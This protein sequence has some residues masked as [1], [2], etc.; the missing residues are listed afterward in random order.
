MRTI[1]FY[2]IVIG[3][4]SGI[5]TRSF[6]DLGIAE[7]CLLLTVS[8]ACAG[9]WRMGVGNYRSS[10][11]LCSL[12]LF[13]F[14]LGMCR[15]DV[16]ERDV[17]AFAL[18][19]NSK[20]Q[21]MG[22]VAREPDI[23]GR[24]VHLYVLDAR[25]QELL[26]V[27][28]DR[29][30]PFLYGDE[31]RVEGIVKKPEAFETDLGRTFNYEGFLKARGVT[32]MIS[33]GEIE[34]LAHGKGN[35]YLA[36]L[37][38]GKTHF[39]E[40]LEQIIPEPSVGLGE[41]L[42]LG[43]KALGSTLEDTFRQVGIIHIVVLSGY[44]IMI[45]VESIMW[46]LSFW[47]YPRTRM[48]VGIA[49][50]IS[51]ALLVGYSA[52][53]LRASIM[54]GL[55]IIAR[56]TGRTYAI[57]RALMI[58]GMVMLLSNPYLLVFDPGFQL[59]FLATLGLLLLAPR[60]NERLTFVPSFAGAREFLTATLATQIFVLPLLLYQMGMFSIVAVVANVLVL[61]IVPFA[62][63]AV[64]L[65]GVIGMVWSSLAVV[66]GFSAHMLLMYIITC[67]Q[68]LVQ[69]PYAW[70]SVPQFPFWIVFVAYAALAL[71][72]IGTNKKESEEEF[73]Q[74]ETTNDH[75]DWVI[76]EVEDVRTSSLR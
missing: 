56:S 61:P 2:T 40:I 13:A 50:V 62:M 18:I 73:E 44:N 53:V 23:R 12:M 20:V 69:I 67:A 52:S 65:T 5:F 26:L 71:F 27:T 25:T 16:E 24:T 49:L 75:T 59:S 43:V 29:F 54:A 70:V 4:A 64:F 45:V 51:F 1:F 19:E 36:L 63:L 35:R 68:F 47:C 66:I 57:V 31:V 42:L 76:E 3:F 48:V 21:V 11:F 38:T 10:L 34:V 6:F 28:T 74:I 22:I 60:I 30:Q 15:L 32:H 14:A 46:V 72:L 58:A 33:F 41:G 55:L 37:Y 7:V 8:I 17:S 9:V 39:L